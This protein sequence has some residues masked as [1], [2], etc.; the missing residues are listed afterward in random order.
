M[1]GGDMD[2]SWGSTNLDHPDT[3]DKLAMDPAMKKEL[4]D[5]LDRFVRRRDFYRKVGKAWKH[6]YL[7]YGPLGTALSSKI[8]KQRDMKRVTGRLAVGGA[9]LGIVRVW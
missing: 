1:G 2:G 7:L 5:D 8:D 3:F 9:R 4:I 6:G